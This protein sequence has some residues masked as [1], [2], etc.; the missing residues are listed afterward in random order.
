VSLICAHWCL[1][2][3]IRVGTSL[4]CPSLIINSLLIKKKMG[5]T[6]VWLEC[7]SSL[8]CVAFTA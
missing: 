1:V 7:D 3:C 5:L 6:N 8:V 4:K 2:L